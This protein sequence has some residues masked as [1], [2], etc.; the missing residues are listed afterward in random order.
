MYY[1]IVIFC[2]VADNGID[3][4][5]LIYCSSVWK[6]SEII[7]IWLLVTLVFHIVERNPFPLFTTFF[8]LDSL[9]F[10]LQIEKSPGYRQQNRREWGH[11]HINV[12]VR[13]DTGGYCWPEGSKWTHAGSREIGL[14]IA[15]DHIEELYK[16]H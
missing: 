13:V 10:A 4:Y 6:S 12:D 11:S 1:F 14:E 3:T 2:Q 15:A 16:L 9:R 8:R 5:T 7:F